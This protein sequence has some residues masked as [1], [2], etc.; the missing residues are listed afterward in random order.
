VDQLGGFADALAVTRQEMGLAADAA[1]ELRPYP[2]PQDLW[3]QALEL[4]LGVR[5]PG[6]SIEAWLGRLSPGTLGTAP[7]VI[8]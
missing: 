5:N 2:P 7:I 1:I 3:D 4:A 6:L 8:R